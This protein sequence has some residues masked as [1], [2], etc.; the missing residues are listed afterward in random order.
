MVATTGQ[1]GRLIAGLLLVCGMAESADAQGVRGPI[2][3]S[4]GSGWGALSDDETNLGRGAPL[5]GGVAVTLGERL[6]LGADLDWTRHVR[7]SGYLRADGD[8][9]GLFGRATWLFGGASSSVRPTLGAGVGV[10][11]STGIFTGRSIVAGPG[12]FPVAGPDERRSWSLTR[13]AWDLH[14]GVRI[15]L[16][17]RVAL[18]PEGRWRATFGSAASTS[19]EPPLLGAQGMM[20]LD[21]DLN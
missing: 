11:R 15:G 4:V 19:I 7:D 5:A 6:R 21:I 1:L 8:L 20:H 2:H 10:L 17:D 13:S 3:L 14:G 16:S 18:R 9:V 12:G